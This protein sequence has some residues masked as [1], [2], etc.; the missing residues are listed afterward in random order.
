ME[1]IVLCYS[2]LNKEDQKWKYSTFKLDFNDKMTQN[3]W[4]V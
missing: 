4:K 2:K 1:S 3:N